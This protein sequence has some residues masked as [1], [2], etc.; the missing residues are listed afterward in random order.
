LVL[1]TCKGHKSNF[2]LFVFTWHFW[3]P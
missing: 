2:A 1:D 3:L